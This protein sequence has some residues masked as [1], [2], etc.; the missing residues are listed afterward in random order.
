MSTRECSECG[1]TCH[2]CEDTDEPHLC[3]SC[4]EKAARYASKDDYQMTQELVVTT[5]RTIMLLPLVPF[6]NSANRAQTIGPIVDPTLYR[7]GGEHLARIKRLAEILLTAQKEIAVVHGEI[8]KE[9]ETRAQRDVPGRVARERE[10][11]PGPP[12]TL[13]TSTPGG[14][15]V[16][17][18]DGPVAGEGSHPYDLQT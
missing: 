13:P 10:E 12:S 4:K 1:E 7:E 3:P 5:C 18:Q 15:S 11:Q 14:E 17:R 2:G 16:L 9:L 6:V 8:K